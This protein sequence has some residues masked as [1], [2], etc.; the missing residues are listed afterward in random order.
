MDDNNKLCALVWI[1]I[2]IFAL[3]LMGTMLY[4]CERTD[5][6]RMECIK[7]GHSPAECREAFKASGS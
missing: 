7:A 1:L 4:S 5:D 2:T 3:A 6:R